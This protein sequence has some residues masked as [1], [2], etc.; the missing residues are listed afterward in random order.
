MRLIRQVLK[1]AGALMLTAIIAG[2]VLF[3][4]PW[5]DLQ[6]WR[7]F[8]TQPV[9]AW[10]GDIFTNWGVIQPL[11]ELRASSKPREYDRDLNPPEGISYSLEGRTVALPD[12]LDRANISGLMVIHDGV[13]K[14]EYYAQGLDPE[15]RNH[16][17][18]ASKS[19]TS[20]LVAMALHEG[21][22]KDL[23]DTV[24]QYAPQ[25][26]GTAYGETPIR[27]VLMMSSGIDFFHGKGKPNRT[28]MY[29]D[30]IQKREDFDQ[31]AARLPRRVPSGT[32]FNYIATDTHVLAAVLRGAY[33]QS[34]PQIVQERLWERGGFGGDASWG[35]DGSGH[36]MGHC[37]L[38]LRLEDFANLGQL[39]V[40]DLKLNGEKTVPE[41]W[42]S[43]VEQ[44]QGDFQ[45]PSFDAAGNMREGY[46][47]QFWIP[48]NYKQE[49]IA[50]GAFGQYLWVDRRQGSVIAQFSLGEPMLFADPEDRI[51][52]EEFAAL[53]RTLANRETFR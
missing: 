9:V 53:M 4:K 16:I 6:S 13:V 7:F 30:I 28:D 24:E 25:F 11:A 8:L 20:T 17:W 26:S 48:H 42:F 21:K 49:F 33:D 37:C 19:F 34:F 18:S 39:Y 22:I 36:A 45:E 52:P 51:S 5:D 14:L 23:D 10:R 41:N 29:W 38:S 47:L 15:S 1:T 12:Y 50:A 35:L 43:L 27:H 40:E 3:T 2:A 44:P 46:S 32:D 31:W